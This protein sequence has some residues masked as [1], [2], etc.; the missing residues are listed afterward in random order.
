MW[1]TSVI[2]L[3]QVGKPARWLLP[4]SIHPDPPRHIVLH[5]CGL[6][7]S[8]C[9]DVAPPFRA[10]TFSLNCPAPGLS[11]PRP[12]PSPTIPPHS[13]APAVRDSR[14]PSHSRGPRRYRPHRARPTYFQRL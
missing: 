1:L 8:S 13:P 12:T 9:R 4:A 5:S 3:R 7:P 2:L 11:P 10:L 6:R 14:K